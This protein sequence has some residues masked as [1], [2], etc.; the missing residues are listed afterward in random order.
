M[1]G[2]VLFIAAHYVGATR[3]CARREREG[4]DGLARRQSERAHARS[5]AQQRH[6]S[7]SGLALRQRGG[8]LPIRRWR[9]GELDKGAN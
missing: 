6:R 7:G 1:H 8:H 5:K 3:A 9:G 2:E 4:G